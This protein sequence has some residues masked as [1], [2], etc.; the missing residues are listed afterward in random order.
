[1][2]LEDVLLDWLIVDR[3]VE[4]V[5]SVTEQVLAL[6]EVWVVELV[7]MGFVKG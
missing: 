7:A 3:G 1:M 6:I 2:I 4:G 5:L